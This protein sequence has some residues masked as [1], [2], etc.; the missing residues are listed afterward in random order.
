VVS[1]HRRLR[2]R[3]RV[4]GRGHVVLRLHPMRLS[5][6]VRVHLHRLHLLVRMRMRVRVRELMRQLVSVREVRRRRVVHVP[7][8]AI[9]PL[10]GVHL[11][12]VLRLLR[13]LHVPRAGPVPVPIVPSSG[14]RAIHIRQRVDV[15]HLRTAEVALV[16][17]AT[18]AGSASARTARPAGAAAVRAV[19]RV[20]KGRVLARELRLDALAVRSVA[21]RGEDGAD[22]LDE[23]GVSALYAFHECI[24]T[25][26]RI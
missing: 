15:L 14:R 16:P 3:L 26:H 12:H 23:L 24:R 11:A 13:L 25:L 9:V 21:D 4:R 5:V 22:A 18:A 20:P 2:V 19:P 6:G 1:L 7:V 10:A 17:A 8:P